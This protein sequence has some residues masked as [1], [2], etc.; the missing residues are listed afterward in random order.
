MSKPLR[1]LIVAPSFPKISETFVTDQIIGLQAL[2]HQVDVFTPSTGAIDDQ[3]HRGE[4]SE[5]ISNFLVPP[6]VP[7]DSTLAWLPQRRGPNWFN[8][9]TWKRLF[10][11]LS[12]PAFLRTRYPLKQGAALLDSPEYDAIICHFGPAGSMIQKMRTI[13]LLKAP[14]VTIFHGYD[15]TSLLSRVPSDFYEELFTHGDLFLPISKRWYNRLGELGCPSERTKL[16]RLGADLRTFKHYDLFP[17]PNQQLKLMTVARLV[18]KKGVEYA[19]RAVGR[20]VTTGLDV[21][22]NIVGDGPMRG[23]LGNLVQEL[24]L[25]GQV[26]FLGTQPHAK[27]AT[28][29]EQHNIL[30]VPSVTD[31]QGCMEGIPVVIME[32]MATGLLVVASRHSGIPEIVHHEENGLLVTERDDAELAEK[33]MAIRNDEDLWKSLVQSAR[34]TINNEYNLQ[35][36][37]HVLATILAEL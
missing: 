12:R 11:V 7:V 5:A 37:N 13:G 9:L 34:V 10:R 27:I 24:G 29:M 21:V 3:V 25:D 16:Q 18:E 2:G 35:K 6:C 8:L 32:A 30:L 20:L 19:I 14:L 15:I 28:L 4:I 17:Q 22:Y 1:L 26:N 23:E 33:M 31:T 36:Q